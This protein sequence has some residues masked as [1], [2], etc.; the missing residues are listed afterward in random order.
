MGNC[1]SMAGT[2]FGKIRGFSMVSRK[3]DANQD[4]H[5]MID[6]S[7]RIRFA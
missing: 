6:H 2:V 1:S 3:K 4:T 5:K 7:I